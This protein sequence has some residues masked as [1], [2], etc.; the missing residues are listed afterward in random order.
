VKSR[1]PVA[2]LIAGAVLLI[3]SGVNPA[4]RT[5]WILEVFPIV[6]AVPLLA[7]TATRFPLTP[8]AYRLIFVHALI[9]MLGGH[10]TYAQVPLGFWMERAFGFTRNHYDRIGHFAQGFVP[11]ILAREILIRRSPL[12]RGRWLFFVVLSVCLAISACYEFI[13]WWSALL[14]GSAAD[15]FLGTQGDPFDTQADMFM[16]LIGAFAAQMLLARVHDRQI[17]EI[18]RWSRSRPAN[19]VGVSS[20]AG[21]YSDS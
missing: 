6:I 18:A 9:L 4:D 3:W 19:G 16:A 17:A 1:E 2:L 5:T 7:A 8:L 10:Y 21:S 11:A 14:G 13:E 12:V 15:A 20:P